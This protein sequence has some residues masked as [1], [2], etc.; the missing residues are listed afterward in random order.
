MIKRVFD[1]LIGGILLLLAAP[2]MAIVALFIALDSGRPIFFTQDRV[3]LH[4]RTFRIFKFR[5]MREGEHVRDRTFTTTDRDQPAFFDPE[6]ASYVTRVGRILRSTSLDELPQ[7]WN[8]L[9]G[10]MSLV[11]PRP[12]LPGDMVLYGDEAE[13]RC[14]VRPGITGLYQVSGRKTLPLGKA[15]ALDLHYVDRHNLF[16]DIWLLLRTPLVLLRPGDAN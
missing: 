12:V 4:G 5:T 1:I 2:L 3:G 6:V 16:Y 7:L 8:V 14:R 11:G 9:L 15:I 10:D 13:K